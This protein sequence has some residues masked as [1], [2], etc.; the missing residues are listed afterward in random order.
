VK[1]AASH[2]VWHRTE[3]DAGRPYAFTTGTQL[4]A[5]FWR[6]VKRVMEEKGILNDL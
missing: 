4:L 3:K 6:E 5:D 2:D 1:G